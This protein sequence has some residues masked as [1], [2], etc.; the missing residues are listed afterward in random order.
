MFGK[1]LLGILTVAGILAVMANGPAW[2]QS[3][4]GAQGNSQ[5]QCQTVVQCRFKRGD[6][7]RGCISAYSCRRCRFVRTRCTNEGRSRTCREL[8]CAWG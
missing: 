7:Y 3:G 1:K 4:P 8:R 5:R 2:A 6:V